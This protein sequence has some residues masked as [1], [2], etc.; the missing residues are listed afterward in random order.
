MVLIAPW[1]VVPATAVY[2]PLGQIAMGVPTDGWFLN[3]LTFS[4]FGVPIAY[5]A[6][7]VLGIPT[8]LA[9]A[10]FRITGW[11]P[12]VIAAV[13]YATAFQAITSGLRL[14]GV[15]V[16]YSGLYVACAIAVALVAR[17]LVLQTQ[18]EGR[19]SGA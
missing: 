6:L 5:A 3:V 12:Y 19:R 1:A 15:F 18:Q 10:K 11:Y 16:L 7:V 9:L 17:I 4:L 14:T 13:V 8:H 2:L